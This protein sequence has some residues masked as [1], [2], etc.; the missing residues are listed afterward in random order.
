MSENSTRRRL[1]QILVDEGIVTENQIQS[2]LSRQRQQGGRIGMHLLMLGYIDEAALVKALTRQSGYQGVILTGLEIP[3]EILKFV[4]ARV[5][6]SRKILP[7]DYDPEDNYLKVACETP[8]DNDL[9]QEL[10]FVARG[11]KVKLHVAAELP[12]INAIA[13]Y[14][15]GMEISPERPFIELPPFDFETNRSSKKSSAKGTTPDSS[16]THLALILS[17]DAVITNSLKMMLEN[18][19]YRVIIADTVAVAKEHVTAQKFDALFIENSPDENRLALVD[20]VRRLAPDT[21][22]R[23]FGTNTDLLLHEESFPGSGDMAVKN[24][25]LL[26]S[27]LEDKDNR[28]LAIG[29]TAGSLVEQL[30]RW[31]KLQPK[32]RQAISSAAYLCSLAH[33]YYKEAQSAADRKSAFAMTARL[34]ETLSY[35]PII[36][37]ILKATYLE[38]AEEY[39]THLPLHILGGNIISVVDHFQATFPDREK[40]TLHKLELARQRFHTFESN[41]FMPDIVKTFFDMLAEK[42]LDCSSMSRSIQVLLYGDAS[43]R[44][45]H[46]EHLLQ[47]D[48]FRTISEC[49]SDRLAEL[50]IRSLPNMIVLLCTGDKEKTLA[51]IDDLRRRG[52]DFPLIPTFVLTSGDLVTHPEPLHQ[53]GIDQVLPL[54]DRINLLGQRLKMIRDKTLR[55]DKPDKATNISERTRQQTTSLAGN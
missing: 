11:K 50:Y 37:D 25:E 7:F 15:M 6:V 24:L 17:S 35:P 14:Y 9:V 51:L 16:T 34:L 27:L 46:I 42:C 36:T 21:K 13:H 12:L 55:N 47:N 19:H 29:E 18:D 4:P 8:G 2:A 41:I 23:M 52:L 31:M 1:D 32:D 38:L 39:S 22:V 53:C 40:L 5:A 28:P 43:D 49:D 26:G 30:C 33:H 10:L 3:M 45:S 20:S 48:G 44:L 54:D